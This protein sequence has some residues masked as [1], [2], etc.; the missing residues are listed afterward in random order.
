MPLPRDPVA[1]QWPSVRRETDRPTPRSVKALCGVGIVSA[2]FGVLVGPWVVLVGVLTREATLLEQVGLVALGVG[3]LALSV[4]QVYALVGLLALKRWAWKASL[5]LFGLHAAIAVGLGNLGNAAFNLFVV[6]FLL[7]QHA[8]FT[9][10]GPQS[11][12]PGVSNR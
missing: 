12:F 4:A 8:H 1:M 7:G 2:L 3:L 9:E 10:T 11:P 5:G 6:L